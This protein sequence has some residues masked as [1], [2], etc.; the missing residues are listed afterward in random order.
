MKMKNHLIGMAAALF[1]LLFVTGCPQEAD[2]KAAG[3]PS[4]LVS[5]ITIAGVSVNPLP[6]GGATIDA[7]G[8][9]SVVVD[10][11]RAPIDDESPDKVYYKPIQPVAVKLADA[12]EIVTFTVTDPAEPA[13]DTETMLP[14]TATG[15]DVT[16]NIGI[17][18]P[19]ADNF[20]AG[21]IVWIKVVAADESKAEFYKISVV[22]KTHDTAINSIKVNGDDVLNNDVNQTGHIGA[23]LPGTTW[24]NAAS[25]LV[26]ILDSQKTA[27][28]VAAITRNANAKVEYAKV[29][30]SD[31]NGAEPAAWSAAA[32]AA[33][34]NNDVLAIKATASNGK[35]VGYLKITV[36]VGGSAFLAS[37][38]VNNKDV[39]LGSPKAA[40]NLNLG[41]FNPY[42]DMGPAYR[43]EDGETLTATSVTWAIAAVPVDASATVTWALVAKNAE[44]AP[45]NFG[46]ATSFDTSHNYL[47]IKVVSKSGQTMYYLVIFD[48]RPKDTEH[49]KT[50]GKS[51]PIYKFTIPNGKT[52]GDLGDSPVLKVTMLMQ[53]EQWD[54]ADGYHR[55]FS[56]GEIQRMADEYSGV[57]FDKENLRLNTGAAS[58]QLFMPYLF[59]VHPKK[60]AIDPATGEYDLNIA[61]VDQWFTVKYPFTATEQPMKQPWDSNAD[62]DYQNSYQVLPSDSTVTY[63]FYPE[64]DATGDQYFGVGITHDGPQEY[65]VKALSIESA[66]GVFKIPCDLINGGRIDG[67]G[68]GKGYVYVTAQPDGT[69]DG[70]V[71]EM[72]SDPT[73]K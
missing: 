13:P 24:A 33:F 2:N 19:D 21:Q 35:T 4:V 63:N 62:W 59:N 52:W 51:V 53:Q 26:N 18:L 41:E 27:V 64:A 65:Y 71:R 8:T 32:P 12:N 30:A 1:A 25:G 70:F 31:A 10:T 58:F 20:P 28:T 56:F 55:N 54:R 15:A 73:L 38:K 43:V 68:T 36:K 14:G 69:T 29:A 72:V 11:E 60:V 6:A 49:L 9:G 50:G 22:N 16:R 61:S 42:S 39:T 47:F 57:S 5:S 48:A 45:T 7:A 23:W 34:D 67:D 17:T 44:P 40:I 37:L 46:A 3:T 66:D